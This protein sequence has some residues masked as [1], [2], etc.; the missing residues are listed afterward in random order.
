MCLVYSLKTPSGSFGIGSTYR[1]WH[2]SSTIRAAH[3]YVL[4]VAVTPIC[5]WYVKQCSPISLKIYDKAGPFRE[6]L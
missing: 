5:E 3:S 4:L 2:F 1:T 6:I